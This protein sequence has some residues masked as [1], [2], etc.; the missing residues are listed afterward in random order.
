MLSPPISISGDVYNSNQSDPSLRNFY[1]HRSS[2]TSTVASAA[3]T[4]AAAVVSQVSPSTGRSNDWNLT[5]FQNQ[6]PSLN[7]QRNQDNCNSRL[8]P[9]PKH[10]SYEK[11]QDMGLSW[12]IRQDTN[13]SQS[14]SNIYNAATQR[15]HVNFWASGSEQQTAEYSTASA[16]TASIDRSMLHDTSPASGGRVFAPETVSDESCLSPDITIGYNNSKHLHQQQQQQQQ[17][18]QQASLKYQGQHPRFG[19]TDAVEVIGSYNMLNGCEGFRP[20]ATASSSSAQ[21]GVVTT[22]S[23]PVGGLKGRQYLYDMAVQLQH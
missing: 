5:S 10:V 18:Q 13:R 21:H 23:M 12:T 6:M 7:P 15:N 1:Q 4:T 8:S 9:S 3:S 17:E 11:G 2:S 20:T 16:V 19:S 14:L 22:G